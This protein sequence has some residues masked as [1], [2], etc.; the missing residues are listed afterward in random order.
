MKGMAFTLIGEILIGVASLIVLL[1]I[2][3]PLPQALGQSY[4]YLHAS[5]IS[6]IP[7]PESMRPQPPAFCDTREMKGFE[8]VYVKDANADAIATRIASYALACLKI[9]GDG[10][11][12]EDIVCYEIYLSDV[13]GVVTGSDVN[14]KVPAKYKSYIEWQAGDAAKQSVLAVYYNAT[15]GKVVIE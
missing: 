1:M 10:T 12:T 5:F 4:C 13:N 15:K 8:R 3:T 2:F 7:F 11:S 6:I 14:N 9:S